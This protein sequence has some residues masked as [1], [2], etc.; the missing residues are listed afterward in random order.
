MGHVGS[1]SLRQRLTLA[2]AGLLFL[3]AWGPAP[4]R[5]AVVPRGTAGAAGGAPAAAQRL[6]AK[7]VPEPTGPGHTAEAGPAVEL[8][9]VDSQPEALTA[10][11]APVVSRLSRNGAAPLLLVANLRGPVDEPTQRLADQIGPSRVRALTCEFDTSPPQLKDLPIEYCRGGP[12]LCEASLAIA[13]QFWART[14][15]VVVADAESPGDVIVG[16]ALAAHKSVPLLLSPRR[17]IQRFLSRVQRDLCPNRILLLAAWENAAPGWRHAV[18]APVDLI[19]PEQAGG[20]LIE[21]VGAGRVR[22]VIVTRLPGSGDAP[23]PTAWLAPYLSLAR[24]A[25]VVLTDSGEASIAEQRV[26]QFIARHGLKPRSITVLADETGI[27]LTHVQLAG[28]SSPGLPAIDTSEEML[29]SVFAFYAEP[30]TMAGDGEA[31]PWAVGRIPFQTLAEASRLVARSLARAQFP[32]PAEPRALVV[33]NPL[34]EQGD[35]PLCETVSRATAQDLQNGRVAIDEFYRVPTDAPDVRAAAARA[36]LIIYEGHLSDQHLFGEPSYPFDSD[37]LM[38]DGD[39]EWERW[40]EHTANGQ[41][42]EAAGELDDDPEP[43]VDTTRRVNGAGQPAPDPPFQIPTGPPEFEA[44]GDFVAMDERTWETELFGFPVIVLQTCS[45]LDLYVSARLNDLGGTALIGSASS[46]HSAS[47]S[48]F[49]K[50]FVDALVYRDA[51][52]GEALR[53][54]RN[55]FFC[56]QDLKDLRK[57]KEQAKSLRVAL[58]FRLWGDPELRV[59]PER[60]PPPKRRPAQAAWQADGTLRINLPA[61]RLPAVQTERY[62]MRAFPGSEAAGIV[63]RSK[64]AATRR[65]LPMH[66]FW[67]ALPEGAAGLHGARLVRPDET[68]DRA[69]FRLDR[70]NDRM[71]VLYFPEAEQANETF[72]LQF[73]R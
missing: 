31:L 41:T 3:V 8:L 33:A 28:P 39:H 68:P 40:T 12:D 20:M 19:T 67:T 35:L 62:V 54:A 29:P 34:P 24:A 47:G 48:T 36:G 13:T 6:P 70:E 37:D 43:G 23:C 64:A 27:G 38:R 1:G 22:N 15:A 57:H 72:T 69:V 11:A 45:S 50:A 49:I 59:F 21:A 53:D 32:R 14:E 52:V 17:R 60:R 46:V 9:L 66:F 65:V 73:E 5:L 25:P 16:A 44:P 7:A 58:S 56:L 2:G 10:L 18:S 30:F 55:Y 42:W 63:K 26:R 51:T 71:C 61:R 4:G